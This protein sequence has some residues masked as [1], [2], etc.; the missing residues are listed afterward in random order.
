MQASLSI[1][2][3]A[4]LLCDRIEPAWLPP[5]WRVAAVAV[6]GGAEALRPRPTSRRYALAPVIGLDAT[7]MELAAM[8]VLKAAD[9]PGYLVNLA[10]GAPTLYAAVEQSESLVTLKGVSASPFEH[11]PFTNPGLVSVDSIA[12][13]R[14]V[15]G[16]VRAFV[17]SARNP[18]FARAG[19]DP[20][21]GLR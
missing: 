4:T 6:A 2:L 14:D 10:N 20:R 17:E 11:D 15:V 9:I 7:M 21:I 1:P 3:I 13:P 16:A 18:G 8:L 19:G 12:M 5:R